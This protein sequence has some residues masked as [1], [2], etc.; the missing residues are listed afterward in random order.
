MYYC[1]SLILWLL[2]RLIVPSIYYIFLCGC[3]TFYL[4]SPM[5]GHALLCNSV[6]ETKLATASCF[7]LSYWS[8]GISKDQPPTCLRS[9]AYIKGDAALVLLSSVP[10]WNLLLWF[11][12]L[13]LQCLLTRLCLRVTDCRLWKRSM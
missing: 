7:P 11:F 8:S 5:S 6:L 12:P 13:I 3:K 10:V 1:I 4:S 9:P 2:H